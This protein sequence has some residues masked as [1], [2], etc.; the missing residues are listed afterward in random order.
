MPAGPLPVTP[1]NPVTSYET[2]DKD[3]NLQRKLLNDDTWRGYFKTLV[4]RAK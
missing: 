4:E 3:G 1:F 2:K